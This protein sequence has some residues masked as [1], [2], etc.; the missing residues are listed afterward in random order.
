MPALAIRAPDGGV[1]AAVAPLALAAAVGTA[2]VVDLDPDGPPYPGPASLASLVSDG[3]RRSDLTPSRRGL[4]VLRNGGVD[5]VDA[6]PV[7]AA[8]TGGWPA[9]V[10]RLPPQGPIPV[11]PAPLV[12]V[13][14]LWPGILSPHPGSGPALYL[15]TGYRQVPP[16]P[17]PVIPMPRRSAVAALLTGTLPAPD[18]RLRAWA[19]VWRFP[20]G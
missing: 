20:W 5:P 13:K 10:F 19:R 8:L 3:P 7:L 16:G 18:H 1:V 15:R 12:P 9:V 4:A 11:A 17:G 6:A 14:P 2:L